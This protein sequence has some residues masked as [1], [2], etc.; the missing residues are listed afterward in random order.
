MSTDEVKIDMAPEIESHDKKDELM[1]SPPQEQGAA[2]K[3]GSSNEVVENE[4]YL[5]QEN[6]DT[7]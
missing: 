6:A 4:T 5:L 1:A 2:S 3:E 7:F